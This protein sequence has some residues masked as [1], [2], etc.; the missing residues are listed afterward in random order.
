VFDL[1]EE[2]HAD[3]VFELERLIA[4]SRKAYE[5]GQPIVEDAVYDAWLDELKQLK[6]DSPEVAA[7]GA[8]PVS[9]WAKVS[10]GFMMGSLDKVNLPVE[11]LRWVEGTGFPVMS[12][13]GYN[14]LFW[15]EK[16]DGISV[17][18]TYLDGKLVQ[19]ATRGDGS[20]GEDIT[21]NVLKMKGVVK[22]VHGFTGSIRGEII[23]LKSDFA[24]HFPDKANTRNTAAGT[25]KRYDGKGCE[26][27]TVITYAVIDGDYT[28]LGDDVKC[29]T[30][31]EHGSEEGMFDWLTS[32][33]FKVPAYETVSS[34]A[35]INQVWAWYQES[36][37]DALDYDIDGLVIR[38]NQM[39]LQMFLGEKDG[40]P[41]GA[42]AFKFAPITRESTIE[43]FD[44]Q[45]GGSGR[46]TPVAVFTP[47]NVLGATITNASVYNIAEIR[48]LNINI[49]AKV[50]VARANDVIPK[51]L[52][53]LDNPSGKPALPPSQCP[54]CG[55]PVEM[56]GEYLTCPN[57]ADCPAQAVGRVERYIKALDIKEWGE[58]LLEKL[59]ASG[60][61]KIIPDLYK[62]TIPVLAEVDRISEHVADKLL[63]LLWAKNPIPL[64]NLLGALSIPGCGSSTIRM[65]MDAGHDTWPKMVAVDVAMLARV[66]GLGPVKSRA[67][68]DWLQHHVT[69]VEELRFLGVKIK[70]IIKGSLTGQSFC[71]TGSMS[72][73]R[74][75]LEAMVTAAGGL[76]KSSVGRGLTFLVIADPNSTSSKAVAARKNGTTCIS[77]EDFV[78]RANT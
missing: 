48:K 58:V 47:V 20:V 22:E 56:E 35:A 76:V 54:V 72:R 75:D 64:E 17:R 33:G 8:T 52:A 46:I 29:A 69:M 30:A 53:G 36:G 63:K 57:T 14:H 34:V 39:S 13:P 60:K 26:H 3:R 55:F 6:A 28:V 4:E 15:T 18:L 9:E 49:G 70:D 78:R 41:L 68:A 32:R 25:S 66:P 40:R 19:A 27:L 31:H 16:L 23:L 71:F 5:A 59:V 2:A 1:V 12:P 62:L 61:V 51:I 21:S 65:V 73:K 67:L 50:L 10:H 42:V 43:R 77:E 45:V 37:R 11:L 7:I 38:I 24:K 44:W 74:G